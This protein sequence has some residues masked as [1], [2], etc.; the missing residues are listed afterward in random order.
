M[1]ADQQGFT[2]LLALFAVG[3]AGLIALKAIPLVE[4][5]ELRE[6]EAELL[7]IGQQFRIA[8][9][10]YYQSTPG[11]LKRFPSKLE[12]LLLDKRIVGIKRHLRR[13]YLDP[14]TRQAEWGLV[15]DVD[16]GIKGVYSLHDGRP[17]KQNGFRPVDATLAGARSYRDWQFVYQ[18]PQIQ[19][20]K[21][22]VSSM[23]E[24]TIQR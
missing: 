11:T 7:Y 13:I 14:M 21:G 2:Y 5:F 6:K 22:T 3:A 8:I 12:D 10:R 18:P 17:I 15:L 16:G 4:T 19:T 9:E 24:S 20:P 23:P 1:K